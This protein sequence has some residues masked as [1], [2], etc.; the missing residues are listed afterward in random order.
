MSAYSSGK[1]VRRRTVSNRCGCDAKVIFKL[2]SG[3]MYRISVFT[4]N[5][6]HELVSKVGQQFLRVNRQ[7][8]F[9]SRKFVFDS[10]KVN[11]GTSQSFRLMKEMVGGYANVGATVRDYR[12]FSRDLKAYVGERD[13]QMI[14]DKFKVKQESCEAFYYAYDVDA[15]GHLT[16]LFWS[17]SIARRN[18]EL[19]GDAVLFDATFDTNM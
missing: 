4:E 13:A 17:D 5:H 11:I 12:N 2:A 14:I 15:E 10:S 1:V 3:K 6:N 18:Y 8:S 19:Y 9:A 16:K 7:M